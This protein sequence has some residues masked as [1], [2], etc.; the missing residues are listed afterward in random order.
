MTGAFPLPAGHR[1]DPSAEQPPAVVAPGGRVPGSAVTSTT[2]TYLIYLSSA[3]L[4]SA[5]AAARYPRWNRCAV[6]VVDD[7]HPPWHHVVRVSPHHRGNS[8]HLHRRRAQR[9]GRARSGTSRRRRVLP[10]RAGRAG[11]GD[12]AQRNAQGTRSWGVTQRASRREL[13]VLLRAAQWK[14]DDVAHNL[15]AGRCSENNANCSRIFSKRLPRC[16]ALSRW[17]RQ[18]CSTRRPIRDSGWR[19]RFRTLRAE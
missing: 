15:P 18:P 8:Q 11:R 3:Y 10:R 13:T 17:C 6:D 4:S 16:R 2:S 19:A 7:S 12:S 9:D 5:E 14:L 1:M